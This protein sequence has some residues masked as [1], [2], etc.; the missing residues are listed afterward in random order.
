MCQ[1]TRARLTRGADRSAPCG[2]HNVDGDVA[3]VLPLGSLVAILTLAR[4][5]RTGRA[6]ARAARP[7]RGG[8]GLLVRNPVQEPSLLPPLACSF[9]WPFAPIRKHGDERR[10]TMNDEPTQ[11]ARE[12]FRATLKA[13]AVS[14]DAAAYHATSTL[15]SF[16][17]SG[18][19]SRQHAV[20][21]QGEIAT[22]WTRCSKCRIDVEVVTA[23]GHRDQGRCSRCRK[24]L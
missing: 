17:T 7:L 6:P 4:P 12:R 10:R 22:R 24:L 1:P 21:R 2:A 20:S 3:L 13:R 5:R 18:P 19:E 15:P 9:P 23:D 16:A 11:R 8:A 14:K